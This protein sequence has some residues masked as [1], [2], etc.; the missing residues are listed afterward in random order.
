[1]KILV[2]AQGIVP[3]LESS[4]FEALRAVLAKIQDKYGVELE[5]RNFIVVYPS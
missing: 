2:E 1:M 5:I 3:T 4:D